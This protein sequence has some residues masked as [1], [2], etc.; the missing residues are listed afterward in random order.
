MNG[1]E[2]IYGGCEDPDAI[3]VKLISSDNHKFLVKREHT[4]TSGT[5]AMLNGPLVLYSLKCF[6]FPFLHTYMIIRIELK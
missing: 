4:L 2:K 3:Y 6:V 1:E 5:G